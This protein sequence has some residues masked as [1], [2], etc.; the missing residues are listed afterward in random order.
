MTFAIGLL[1]ALIGYL[2]GCIS[3]AR[4]IAGRILPGE[5]ISKTAYELPE[6]QIRLE[7]SSVSA[8]SLSI[9]QKP[10]A[11]CLVSL[12]DMLKATI[13]V[14]AFRLLYPDQPFFLIAAAMVI[15]GHNWPVQHRFQGGRG[16]SSTFGGL[17]VID[18]WAI[19]A[20]VLASNLFGLIVLRDVFAAY[21][22]F[23]VMLIPWLWFR[24]QDPWYVAYGVVAAFTFLFAS[25]RELTE[26]I[27]IKRSGKLD[28]LDD[29]LDVLEKT[30]MGKPMK[31]LRKYGLIGQKERPSD[32]I[33]KDNTA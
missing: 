16:L 17:F 8:T 28:D 22:G 19:P 14:L 26:Y 21:A 15:V 6:K 7:V 31:Y 29:F 33:D 3:F 25:R 10:K 2:F 27:A 23:G 20:A 5:D 4:M 12:L 32:D 24:F 13:P 1:A 11:G 9:R 30:D 18:I